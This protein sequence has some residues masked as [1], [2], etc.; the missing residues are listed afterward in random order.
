MSDNDERSEKEEKD[1]K[2][3]TEWGGEK[4]SGEKWA[5]DPLGRFTFALIIIW[6]GVVFLLQNLGDDGQTV[7]G[8]DWGNSWAWIFTGAGVL[9]WIEVLIRLAFPAYRRPLGGRLILGTFFVVLGAGWLVDVNLWP[10]LI[11]AI[12][13]S[14]LVGYFFGPRGL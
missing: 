11:V 5:G 7:L 13:I 14:M 12:G 6:A 8:V 4:W 9:I 2:G 1:E 10:L 3:D